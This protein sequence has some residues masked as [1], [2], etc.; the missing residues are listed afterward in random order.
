M[1]ECIQVITTTQ[2]RDAAVQVAHELVLTRLAAC[3]QIDGPIESF[4]HWAGKLQNSVEWRC[5]AKT[6]R[7]V[8]PRLEAAI[9]RTHPYE[10][11]EIVSVA[12]DGVSTDYLHWMRE[13]IDL[14]EQAG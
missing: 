4:Y 14:E 5:T 12:I 2:T 1:C 6:F 7:S 11:P 10:T 3:V 13:N 8:L 9:R